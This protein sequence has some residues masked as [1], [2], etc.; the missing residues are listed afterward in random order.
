MNIPA[1]KDADKVLV[2]K[3][4]TALSQLK[5]IN[6][7]QYEA[8]LEYELEIISEKEYENYFLIV[9]DYVNY[10][11]E[12]NIKVAP[13]RGSCVGSLVAFLLGITEIDPVKYNLMFERFLSMDRT[14]MP[15][16][17]IDVASDKRDELVQYIINT[18]G[19]NQ[20]ARFLDNTERGIH[21]SGI[22]IANVDLSQANTTEKDNI[23][24]LNYPQDEVEESL[25]KFDILSSNFLSY[26]KELEDTT[27]D[28][29]SIKDN[30][31]DDKFVYKL[32]N[33]KLLAGL[34]QVSSP[35]Y[36][37]RLCN[38]Q[39]NSIEKLADALALI[40]APFLKEKL[41]IQYM[42]Q[43]VK[44]IND[45]YDTI[46]EST[47]GV[48]L[49]QE[50]LIELL[51]AYNFSMKEAYTIMKT[52]AKGNSIEEYKEKFFAN[53]NQNAAL[54]W[55]IINNMG[56]YSFNRAH[57]IAYA[58]LVYVTAYYKVYYTKE[59]YAMMLTKAYGHNRKAEIKALQKELKQLQI[60]LLMPEF[61]KSSYE[62]TVELKGI[63][64]GLVAISGINKQ[65]AIK[66]LN[67]ESLLD[68]D[69]RTVTLAIFAGVF[70]EVCEGMW[71][72]KIY[73]EFMEAK[74]LEPKETFYIS[75][76][77]S[78]VYCDSNRVLNNKIMKI[79]E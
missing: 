15:D 78:F 41:D 74:G 29:I 24:V 9:A 62:C 66:L 6:V 59:F 37:Q 35:L 67:S 30:N 31:F 20:V 10:A 17:D 50:Q 63:R 43:S 71:R 12:Y 2:N 18:Y 14:E 53:C 13:G 57:A 8:R 16:I 70:D 19:Y 56:L 58:T 49:Y 75:P 1:I 64:L 40:R 39:I 36:Q 68:N 55:D 34:F 60:Q 28:I 51:Y 44:N 25:V 42:N 61:T 79:E 65:A 26:I 54:V 77:V 47:N 3:V 11:K 48:L 38:L 21:Q 33:T 72:Y 76:K 73:H 22:I 27:G 4:Y 45:E 23:L 7:E 52:L 69:V 5:N 46:T 32:L